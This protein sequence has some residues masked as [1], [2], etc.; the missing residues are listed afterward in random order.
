MEKPIVKGKLVEEEKKE[1][2]FQIKRGLLLS[3]E[4]IQT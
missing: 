3:F 2:I 1:V 4:L